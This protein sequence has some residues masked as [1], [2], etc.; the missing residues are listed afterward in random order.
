MFTHFI[1]LMVISYLVDKL[2]QAMPNP[3]LQVEVQGQLHAL[4]S[5]QLERGPVRP[6]GGEG[7]KGGNPLGVEEEQVPTQV[8]HA[9]HHDSST[10]D[11]GSDSSSP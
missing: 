1:G 11:G 4:N 8:E 6:P 5:S 2:Q 10:K 7:S 9:H 3:L